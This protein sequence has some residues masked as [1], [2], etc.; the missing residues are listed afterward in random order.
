MRG[1]KLQESGPYLE[2]DPN[3]GQAFKLTSTTTKKEHLASKHTLIP[4]PTLTFC[5]NAKFQ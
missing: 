2:E 3:V 1:E 5:F 4:L